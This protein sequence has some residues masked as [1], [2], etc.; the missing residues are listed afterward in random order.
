M[1]TLTLPHKGW[2]IYIEVLHYEDHKDG[3]VDLD[4][5]IDQIHPNAESCR[6]AP[7]ASYSELE[8]LI[9]REI[10]RMEQW[11]AQQN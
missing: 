8:P 3:T 7:F 11:K 10:E 4:W 9:I 1:F 5:D 2:D 6:L